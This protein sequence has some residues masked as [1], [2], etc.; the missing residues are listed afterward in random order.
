MLLAVRDIDAS[1]H[2]SG[3]ENFVFRCPAGLFEKFEQRVVF[4]KLKVERLRVLAEVLE[5]GGWLFISPGT[6]LLF[7]DE[8]LRHRVC[9]GSVELSVRGEPPL[10]NLSVTRL[11]CSSK[12]PPNTV[13]CPRHFNTSYGNYIRFVFGGRANVDRFNPFFRL[14]AF[15]YAVYYGSEPIKVGTV[16]SFKGSRRLLEQPGLLYSFILAAPSIAEARIAEV[17]FSSLPGVS[18][19]PSP[20]ERF[21]YLAQAQGRSAEEHLHAFACRLVAI[22]RRARSAGILKEELRKWFAQGKPLTVVSIEWEARALGTRLVVGSQNINKTLSGDSCVVEG[23]AHG[24][25]LLNCASAGRVVVPYENL[26]D[27]A[28]CVDLLENT[29]PPHSSP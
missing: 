3:A 27:R 24:A 16:I 20:K 29:A 19:A 26:R 11:G 18:Q 5:G 9:P 22:L 14:P 1:L 8:P 12:P 10:L 23:Y 13:F 17:A 28:L 7:C 21:S 6:R 25:L 15:L 2:C 4:L